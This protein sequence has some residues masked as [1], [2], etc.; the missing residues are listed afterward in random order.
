MFNAIQA[1]GGQATVKE[2][3]DKRF[4]ELTAH[5][6]RRFDE[7]AKSFV[8]EVHHEARE[9]RAHCADTSPGQT[10]WM[11]AEA[12][13]L[14]MGLPFP[15]ASPG[16]TGGMPA[17]ADELDVGVPFPSEG[18]EASHEGSHEQEER[19]AGEASAVHDR[20]QVHDAL[21]VDVHGHGERVPGE[22][23]AAHGPGQVQESPQLGDGGG[24]EAQEHAE[25]SDGVFEEGE[26]REIHEGDGAKGLL[27]DGV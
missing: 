18:S 7:A 3:V 2:H 25:D 12:D 8:R 10:G 27:Q 26:A 20:D 21:H 23:T 11:P 19:D 16:E 22:V 6:N 15:S 17:K 14:E 5:V 13:E 4:H 9:S 1:L 24:Q